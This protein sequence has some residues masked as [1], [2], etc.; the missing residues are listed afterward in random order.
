MGKSHI[1]VAGGRKLL[2]VEIL[3]LSSR[4]WTN[5]PKLPH[6]MDHAASLQIDDDFIILGGSSFGRL[7]C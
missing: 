1:V 3:S 2:E 7:P 4:K 5:G 6:E